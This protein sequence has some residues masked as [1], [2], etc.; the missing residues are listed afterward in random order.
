MRPTTSSSRHDASGGSGADALWRAY[1]HVPGFLDPLVHLTRRHVLPALRSSMTLRRLTGPAHPDG[2]SASLLAAGASMTLDHLTAE[3]FRAPPAV[4]MLGPVTRAAL[5]DRLERLAAESDLVLACLPTAWA[6]DLNSDYLRLPAL[7]GA[8]VRIGAS[9]EDTLAPASRTVRA[10]VRLA[11]RSGYSWHVATDRADFERF[12]DA[13]YLPFIRARFG[14]LGSPRGRFELRREFR[15]GGAVMWISRDG[16]L[17]AGGI[18]RIKGKVLHS[19]AEA[20]DP[21]GSASRAGPQVACNVASLELALQR[22][23]EMVHLGGAV[24]SLTNG[25]VRKKCAWGA[26]LAPWQESHRDILLRWRVP[27]SASVRAFLHRVAPVFALS[28]GLAAVT[29]ETAGTEPGRWRQLRAP[30]I[31]PLLV[32]GGKSGSCEAS[33]WTTLPADLDAGGVQRAAL[34]VGAPP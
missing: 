15:H 20:I 17:V 29:A 25:I 10:D 30:G 21:A 6:A 9:L 28:K 14:A 19:L 7:I 11:Q 1:E 22:G 12:Y 32:L 34:A 4:E 18:V 3:F 27:L 16:R 31:H 8:S 24:P 23:L 13:F 2:R 5:P 33:G 26:V